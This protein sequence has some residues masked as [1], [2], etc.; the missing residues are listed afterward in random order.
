MD[1]K[2]AEILGK[3]HDHQRTVATMDVKLD[4]SV[5]YH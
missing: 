3:K 2:V 1:M 4:F 5:S